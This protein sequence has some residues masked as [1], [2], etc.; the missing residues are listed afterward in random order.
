MPLPLPLSS[1]DCPPGVGVGVPGPE[2]GSHGVDPPAGLPPSPVAPIVCPGPRFPPASCAL[3]CARMGGFNACAAPGCWTLG[4]VSSCEC[5][6][7]WNI[8]RMSSN[9]RCFREFGSGLGVACWA[10]APQQNSN[11]TP[12]TLVAMAELDLQDFIGIPRR[13][14]L[15]TRATDCG[16]L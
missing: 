16:R 6:G 2:A 12:S 7:S 4:L 14:A 9:D 15:S 10:T 11:V 13:Q 1:F 3:I 8:C 5:P